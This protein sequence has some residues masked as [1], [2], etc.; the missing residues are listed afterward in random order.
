MLRNLLFS[1][2]N[3]KIILSKMVP[4]GYQSKSW[5]LDG[6]EN[7]ILIAEKNQVVE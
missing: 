4:L 3:F 6:R 7:V 5:S 2:N 1:N